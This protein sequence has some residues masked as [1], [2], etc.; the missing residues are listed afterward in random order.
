MD[1]EESQEL[2]PKLTRHFR[3]EEKR[4][5]Q[6]VGESYHVRGI[7]WRVVCLRSQAKHV[8]QRG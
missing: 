1:E 4:D 3:C 6:E 8:F 7:S 5:K 2:G